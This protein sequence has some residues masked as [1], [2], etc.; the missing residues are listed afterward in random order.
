MALT[1]EQIKELRASAGIPEQ[2]FGPAVS[3][4]DRI[5][6][7]RE[8]SGFNVAPEPE[9]PMLEKVGLDF[10]NVGKDL[11]GS[12]AERRQ[13]IEEANTAFKEGKQGLTE[14][15]ATHIANII[16]GAGDITAQTV[17]RPITALLGSVAGP[18]TE[19]LGLMGAEETSKPLI[20]MHQ[21]SGELMSQATDYAI[22]AN[23]E[24]DPAKKQ[25]LID[26]SKQITEAANE[27]RNAATSYT[28]QLARGRRQAE[29][30]RDIAPWLLGGAGAK[31]IV[32]DVKG[33]VKVVAEGADKIK[34][35]IKEGGEAGLEK[36]KSG[37][38]KIKE[39]PGDLL[40]KGK[41]KFEEVAGKP[42]PKPVENVLKETPSEMFDKYAQTAKK[43]AESNKNPTPLEL[44]G[45]RAGEAL[46]TIQ[47][48]LD[49]YGKLKNSFAS[50]FGDRPVGTIAT[51]FAQGLENFKKAKTFVEG[52]IKLV[53]DLITKAKG[54]GNNPSALEV[55]QF[56]DYVQDKIYTSGRDLSIPVTDSTTASVRNI[57]GELNNSLKN[58]LP[59][60]Y[61]KLNDKYSDLVDVRNELNTKLGKEGEKGGALMKRVFSPSDA[62]TKKLFARVL[63]ETGID[64]V[65]EATLSKFLMEAVGDARQMSLLEQLKLPKLSA[66]GMLEFLWDKFTASANTPEKIIE[67]AR[68]MTKDQTSFKNPTVGQTVSL[69]DLDPLYK[70]APDA[71]K[72]IDTLGD[73]IVAKYGG[74]VAKT[75]FKSP[76]RALEK[77]MKDKGGDVSKLTDVVRNTVVVT[78]ENYLSA[79]KDLFEKDGI[80]NPRIE[81]PKVNK[82]GYSGANANIKTPNGHIAEIQVNTPDMIFAK[83]PSVVAKNILG[84]NLYNQLKTKYDAMGVEGGK[85]HKYY[86]QIYRDAEMKKPEMAQT[87]ARIEEES[88]KYY[89][90]F[91]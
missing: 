89:S 12:F 39:T 83:E 44:A 67:R 87:K 74:I 29:I 62:N 72:F 84:E 47:G 66:K 16:G 53:D 86:E 24:T 46:D 38:E 71:K 45:Q 75:D 52:D 34:T 8:K 51:K 54:L 63:E 26:T 48:K 10:Q 36:L 80:I 56:I 4:T 49:Q 18:I 73:S 40:E 50:T 35:V 3:A 57:L 41:V 42:T 6:K 27:A 68:Q 77:V 25:E 23:A 5:A 55:D 9:K 85:G 61:R 82:L 79:I 14:T 37:V 58:E 22:R 1:P 19:K 28:E 7:L 76:I 60:G 20:A 59:D 78:K 70:Q 13:S 32:E 33:K 43:A 69:K 31:K 91:Y 65:N 30:V 2:G 11:T 81:N 15:V 64:L 21:I 90:N 17:F 88:R